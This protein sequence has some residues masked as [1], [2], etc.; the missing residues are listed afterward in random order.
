MKL[1]FISAILPGL[2]RDEVFEFVCS[3]RFAC[4]ELMCWPKETTARIASQAGDTGVKISGPGYY[5]NPLTAGR[6]EVQV[7]IDHLQKVIP[8]AEY[9]GSESIVSAR[10]ASS[11]AA[12]FP[13]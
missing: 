4:A 5:P 6:E 13:C 3:K 9:F 11:P 8:A 10:C 2:S 1:G 12:S 7:Y